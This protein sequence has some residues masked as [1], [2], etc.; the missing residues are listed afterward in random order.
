MKQSPRVLNVAAAMLVTLSAAVAGAQLP[1][2]AP[3]KAT[4]K[5]ANS[6][7]TMQSMMGQVQTTES[8]ADQ[9]VT[10]AILKDGAG[11]K[12]VMTFDTATATSS[13]PM[14]PAPDFGPMIGLT[15]TGAMT[16]EGKVE[17]FELTA[18]GGGAPTSPIASNFR[19]LLPR[20]KVGAKVGDSWTD[21]TSAS[22]KQNGADVQTVTLSTAKYAGDTTV[23][24]VKAFKITMSSTAK[25]S[26]SGNQSGADFTINGTQKS[27]TVVLLGADGVLIGL[28]S[29]G[30]SDMTVEVP[31]AG[32]SI[33]MQM[34]QTTVMGKKN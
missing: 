21:S 31:Q 23:S 19:P 33:P 9:Q 16:P 17:K 8:T 25:I 22:Q 32:M 13:N 11:L 30:A 24:G 26:G 2:Y 28:T 14:A 20:L 18:K 15:L 12:L 29:D 7:A 1:G 4:Y 3:S 10:I 5:V 34:K 6:V 27:E